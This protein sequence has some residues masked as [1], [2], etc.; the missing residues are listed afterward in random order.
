MR[1]ITDEII[2]SFKEYLYEEERSDNTY[3]FL[4]MARRERTRQGFCTLPIFRGCFILV[5]YTSPV[6]S[7]RN[8][9]F[10]EDEGF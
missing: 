1:K 10:L 4:C 5:F 3:A 9:I 2:A 7:Y 6:I 8:A